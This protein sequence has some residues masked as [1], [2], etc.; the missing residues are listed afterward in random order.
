MD[1]SRPK[2]VGLND[3]VLLGNATD[4][5]VTGNLQQRYMEDYIYTNI[6]P[7]LIAVNPFK[8]IPGIYTDAVIRKYKGRNTFELVPH[9]YALAD[10][11]LRNLTSFRENQCIIITGESGSGK[12]ETSKIVMQYIAACT[13]RSADVQRVKERM[14][15]SNPVLE[16]F[17]NAKTLRNDNSSRFGKYMRIEFNGRGDPVGGS[18]SSYLLEKIRVV[19]PHAGERNFHIFYQVCAGL[20]GNDRQKYQVYGPDQ[21]QYLSSSKCYTIPGTDDVKSFQA[22]MNGL[23]ALGATTT[24]MQSILSVLSA[25]LWLGNVTFAEDHQEKSSV[26]DWDTLDLVASLLQVDTTELASAM[27]T[28][29]IEM[30]QGT[31]AEVYTKPLTASDAYITRDTLAKALYA[32]L[33]AFVVRLVNT[34]LAL[35]GEASDAA[36]PSSL[37]HIGLLDIYGFEIFKANSFEQLCINFVNERLQQVFIEQ[38]LRAEQD[39]YRQEGIPWQ[40]VQYYNNK[41][42]CDLIEAKPGVFSILDDACNT[43]KGDAGFLSDLTSFF[44][45][46]AF[47]RG[48]TGHSFVIAHYAGDV[49]YAI[50]GFTLKNKDTLFDDLIQCLQRSTAPFVVDHGWDQIEVQRGQKKKPPTVGMLFKG[51]V[52]ELMGELATCTP[53]YCR[54]IKPNETKRA[55]D[56]DVQYTQN[57]VQYL[58][59][60]ENIRVRQAGYAQKF[61]YDRFV[62][63]YAICCPA[64]WNARSNGSLSNPGR[65]TAAILQQ[66]QWTNGEHFAMGRTKVFIRHAESVFALETY[67][68]QVLNRSALTIQRAFK[69]F[70]NQRV[71]LQNA[72][73]CYK[74]FEQR[75]ERRPA[76][77]GRYHKGDYINLCL[78]KEITAQFNGD[79]ILFA[80]RILDVMLKG[81]RGML[82]QLIKK[83]M[84]RDQAR[85]FLS[86]KFV[87]LTASSLFC[88]SMT[89]GDDVTG[90]PPRMVMEWR[91]S[92]QSISSIAMSPYADNVYVI[93]SH[94]AIPVVQRRKTE[95]I[96][97]MVRQIKQSYRQ[98]VPLHIAPAWPLTVTYK[99]HVSRIEVRFQQRPDGDVEETIQVDNGNIVVRVGHGIPGAMFQAPFQP[100][101]IDRTVQVRDVL[102]A[103]YEYNGNGV[104]EL[105]IQI[106]DQLYLLLDDG[107]GW[108]RAELKNGQKGYI[109]ASYVKRV[110]RGAKASPPPPQDHRPAPKA[111]PSKHAMASIMSDTDGEAADPRPYVG[112]GAGKDEN[113]NAQAMQRLASAMKAPTGGP[114]P[115]A[116]ARAQTWRAQHGQQQ[117]QE[118]VGRVQDDDYADPTPGPPA[119]RATATT[120]RPAASHQPDQQQQ[121]PQRQSSRYPVHEPAGAGRPGGQRRP[122]QQAADAN[123]D[124]QPR[125]TVRTTVLPKKAV[126]GGGG[127]PAT[128]PANVV[129]ESWPADDV[130]DAPA[131][132][133]PPP[134][135]GPRARAGPTGTAARQKPVKGP[136]TRTLHEADDPPSASEP[137]VKLPPRGGG[138]KR[139]KGSGAEIN[140]DDWDDVPAPSQA[141]Q[142]RGRPLPTTRYPAGSRPDTTPAPAA[143]QSRRMA[144]DRQASTKQPAAPP[145][146]WNETGASEPVHSRATARQQRQQQWQQQKPPQARMHLQAAAALDEVEW[147][148]TPEPVINRVSFIKPRTTGGD[149]GPLPKTTGGR[150]QNPMLADTVRVASGKLAAPSRNAAAGSTRIS[151]K[152]TSAATASS[153]SAIAAA[154][155]SAPSGGKLDQAGQPDWQPYFDESSNAYY[156]YNARTGESSWD[157]PRNA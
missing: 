14:L 101:E 77:V 17:G 45:G 106:G 111:G 46:N 87:A 131:D 123:G 153:P 54:C 23:Q 11:A 125:L 89:P 100:R 157:K 116:G 136:S 132:H 64:V 94:S 53:H 70:A 103:I 133:E 37:I 122:Q 75:K 108:Y 135:A 93:E 8:Q 18:I 1:L 119:S 150:A 140:P 114:G 59:L 104:D 41:P 154:S 138:A 16:A 118:Q 155:A 113:P 12:T 22:T 148:D 146:E 42:C 58:G 80:D 126:G 34:S 97:L 28:R 56:F 117:Q 102:E 29:T 51:Q 98:Q 134:S 66:L 21:Y 82:R 26:H 15:A 25:I 141:V 74:A 73:D 69:R 79:R 81:K 127:G 2:G 3:L 137:A 31:R 151:Q 44:G 47:L 99:G 83:V 91:L 55:R 95:L 50:Q 49:Q 32:R 61:P 35:D 96:G 124:A 129:Q 4:A 147:S 7:V 5:S 40:D 90:T 63:R 43:S 65:A 149:P 72:W 86:S 110:P 36:D 120:G 115:S 92:L 112:G 39:E 88:M 13:G 9:V 38:T 105:S 33:F 27:T 107:D 60:V 156:W 30:G 76:S 84:H 62:A 48:G 85:R 128:L 145:D 144:P 78:Y 57:Q 152:A 71:A 67:R 109:P 121:S 130:S 68:E 10:Q 139:I 52:T 20:H 6:G 19:D 143:V 142:G 24:Q